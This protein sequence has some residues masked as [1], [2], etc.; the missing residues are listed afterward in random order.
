M[1]V[2][3]LKDYI[4]DLPNDLEVVIDEEDFEGDGDFVALRYV[5]RGGV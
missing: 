2:G 3:E 5:L 1:T 4:K